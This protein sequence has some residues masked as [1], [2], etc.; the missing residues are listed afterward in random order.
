MYFMYLCLK[1]IRGNLRDSKQDHHVKNIYDLRQRFKAYSVYIC[2][3]QTN[4]H[5]FMDRCHS[6]KKNP[7]T[8]NQTGCNVTC[9]AESVSK[10]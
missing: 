4:N 3:I 2:N 6:R 1:H 7:A 5:F 9:V 8:P 10:G